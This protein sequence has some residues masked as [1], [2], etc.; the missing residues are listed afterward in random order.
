MSGTLPDLS[1]DKRSEM[2]VTG[3]TARMVAVLC[4]LGGLCSVF[5][6]FSHC[7][8]DPTFLFH[9]LCFATF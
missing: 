9:P 8:A 7:T 3:C 5:G 4:V 2:A 6:E 1:K